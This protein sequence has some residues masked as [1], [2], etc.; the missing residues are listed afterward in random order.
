MDVEAGEDSPEVLTSG[1][2]SATLEI[3][4]TYARNQ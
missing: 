3:D 1:A 4:A 2:P